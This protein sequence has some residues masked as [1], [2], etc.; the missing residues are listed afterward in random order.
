M[1]LMKRSFL[2]L[3]G[4]AASVA[5][6]ALPGLARADGMTDGWSWNEGAAAIADSGAKNFSPDGWSWGE[7]PERALSSSS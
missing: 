1:S 4:T 7:E 6:L 5:A 3:F 2:I